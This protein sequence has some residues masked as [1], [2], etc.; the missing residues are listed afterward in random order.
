[1]AAGM[2]DVVMMWMTHPVWSFGRPGDEETDD[3]AVMQWSTM[4]TPPVSIDRLYPEENLR[5]D[6]DR[7]KTPSTLVSLTLCS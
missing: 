1:M 7:L 3:L 2:V 5:E 6:A 4:T